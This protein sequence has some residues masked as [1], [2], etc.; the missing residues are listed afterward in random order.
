MINNIYVSGGKQYAFIHS[1]SGRSPLK[2]V[3][4]Y[5]CFLDRDGKVIKIHEL[6]KESKFKETASIEV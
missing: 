2:K 6:S 3:G 4:K 5:F 1:V